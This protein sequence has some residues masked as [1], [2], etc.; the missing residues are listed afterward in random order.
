MFSV[1]SIEVSNGSCEHSG[2]AFYF[3]RT[4]SADLIS[5]AR[6]EHFKHNS[7]RTASTWKIFRS[8]QSLY[9]FAHCLY[10]FLC[11]TLILSLHWFNLMLRQ[12]IFGNICGLIIFCTNTISRNVLQHDFLVV[13]WY[14]HVF[15]FCLLS[16]SLFQESVYVK[17]RVMFLGMNRLF[18]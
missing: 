8:Q 7:R 9:C 10:C 6:S 5:L 12:P 3:A 18:A 13:L 11:L 16:I 14:H 2:T 17:V 4:S 1:T 15:K